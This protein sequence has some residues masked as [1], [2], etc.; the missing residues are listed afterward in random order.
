MQWREYAEK[1]FFTDHYGKYLAD[2][3]LDRKL[4]CGA[5]DSEKLNSLFNNIDMWEK[6]YLISSEVISIDS[7]RMWDIDLVFGNFSLRAPAEYDLEETMSKIFLVQWALLFKDNEKE[8][9][10]YIRSDIYHNFH[11]WFDYP[12]ERCAWL[13]KSEFQN[14]LS[15]IYNCSYNHLQQYKTEANNN[16]KRIASLEPQYP[17][18]Q[19]YLR[20]FEDNIH[21][22]E[23]IRLNTFNLDE[24]MWYFVK[25]DSLIYSIQISDF[26]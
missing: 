10:C 3:L 1:I 7:Y 12:Q 23:I 21:N 9:N 18:F 26:G 17:R 15:D 5:C 11:I 24:Y 22:A 25:A 14:E 6:Q 16:P 8:K 19:H 13:S 2:L 4:I 20:F